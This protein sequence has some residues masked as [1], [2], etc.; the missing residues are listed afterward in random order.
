MKTKKFN[1][2]RYIQY[3]KVIYPYQVF[4]VRRHRQYLPRGRIK[5]LSRQVLACCV[6]HLNGE[7]LCKGGRI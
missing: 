5:R 3:I 2:A 1:L 4:A 6:V 7:N